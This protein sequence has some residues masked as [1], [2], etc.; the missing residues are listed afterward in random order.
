M[1]FRLNGPPSRS[2]QELKHGLNLV[3]SNSLD[4]Q[5]RDGLSR[6]DIDHLNSSSLHPHIV[7]VSDLDIAAVGR[8][9]MDS[10]STGWRYIVKLHNGI[11]VAAEVN[12][13]MG[14]GEFEFAGINRGGYVDDTLRKWD[15]LIR[16]GLFRSDCDAV[17]L[18]LPALR[19][20][21]LGVRCTLDH[22]LD[23]FVPLQG[24]T[25][26]EESPPIRRFHEMEIE[27]RE[28]ALTHKRRNE[29]YRLNSSE[30]GE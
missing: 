15:M 19:F 27:L 28:R 5:I 29:G 25:S 7:F 1:S 26:I 20:Q 17:L 6:L 24:R 10:F 12:Q 3:R 21:A 14:M 9:I 22:S 11:T 8:G 13:D 18:K 16:E 4:S 30:F 2:I 23:V